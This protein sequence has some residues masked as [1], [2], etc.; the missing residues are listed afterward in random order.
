M[1]ILLI[2]PP[3]ENMVISNIPSFVQEEGG[4]YPPLGLM[5]V[6]SYAERNTEH[7]IE[8]LDTQVEKKGYN[9]I[10]KEIQKRKRDVVGISSFTFTLI[11]AIST[12]K[13]VKR[14][15]EDVSVILGGPHVNIYPYES[16][17]IPEVDYVVL[18]EGEITFTELI[19]NLGDTQKLGIVLINSW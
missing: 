8:I 15:D 19:Q 14:V 1:K 11:D 5:Y 3:D 9:D 6:A 4:F 12:A 16:I 13:I 17:N 18:G 7:N 2:Y 10:E